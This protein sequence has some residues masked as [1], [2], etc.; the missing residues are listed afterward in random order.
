[1]SFYVKLQGKEVLEKSLIF[2]PQILYEPWKW[3]GWIPCQAFLG[4]INFESRGGG[5]GGTPYDDQHKEALARKL[6]NPPSALPWLP[7]D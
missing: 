4:L 7:T 3:Q 2:P 6:T 5:G 1:M